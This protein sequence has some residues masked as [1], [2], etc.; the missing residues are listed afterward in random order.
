MKAKIFLIFVAAV[1]CLKV[2]AQIS[3]EE[4][5][6]IVLERS[7]EL[8]NAEAQSEKLLSESAKQR[9]A[10]L[11]SLSASGSFT[12]DFKRSDGA[13][14]WGFSVEPRIEQT[15]YAGGGVRAAYRQALTRYAGSLQ[16]GE[17]VALDVRMYLRDEVEEIISLIRSLIEA[18]CLQAEANKGTILPGYTHLQ[19]AQPI[20]FGHHLMAYA[21]MLLRDISRLEDAKKRMNSSPIGCCAL[22]GTTYDTDRDFEAAQL[23]FDSVILNS[24]DGVSDRDFCIELGAAFSTVMMHLSRFSEEIILW[25]SSE[26]GFIELIVTDS[27]PGIEDKNLEAIFRRFFQVSE[28]NNST[29]KGF[30]VG[31]NLCQMLVEMHNGSIT[32]SNR[33]DG[34]S[35]AVF[36]VKLP[37][38]HTATFS[39]TTTETS[40]KMVHTFI[41]TASDGSLKD[42]KSRVKTTNRILIIEDD[43]EILMFLK[44]S[45]SP[46]YKVMTSNDGDIGLQKALT[47]LPDLIISDVIMPGTD[48]F[49]IVKRI[50]NNPNT[51]HI[52]VVL[53]TSKADM[54]DRLKGI[55]YGAD[56]Y[57]VK[58][59][60]IDELHLTIENLLK[61]R[62]R[63]KGK[64][65]GSFQEDKIKTIEIKGN[66][67]KLMEKILKVVNDNLD[68]PDLKVEMLAEEVGLS[69]A[70]LHRRIKEMTGISTGE[71]I[72]NIRLKKA[73]EL[74]SEKK[75]NISQ[76]A[77][78]VGFSK[79]YGI[80]PTEYINKA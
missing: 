33:T 26:Y 43:E 57:M 50:K 23:G 3:I 39:D 36:T 13:D 18:I 19:R 12:T 2:Q 45:M 53:L 44:E 32:A 10:F 73:A 76:V 28:D 25:C 14:L 15:I 31:L 41:S 72:R 74:L 16:D 64:Y 65:S 75:I 21:M 80:S 62:Q 40:D 30:G 7:L 6:S 4:Y 22:A 20:T 71:F 49:Q 37:F 63:I 52:P 78:M 38:V 9:T 27:G 67:D 69:R 29:H 8:Q 17:Q 1:T 61:N 5:R 24:L 54:S 79:Y 47:E 70:Q 35:G 46:L 48:G 56:A 66:S 60:N 55:E 51:T 59:F 77:Y 58:P 11:P 34:R 42:R 68:N